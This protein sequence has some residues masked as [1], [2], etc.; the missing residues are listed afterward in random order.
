VGLAL[1]AEDVRGDDFALVLT[2]V[3]QQPDAGDVADGPQA[4]A[5]A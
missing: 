5:G 2:D 4:L 1:F 3:G